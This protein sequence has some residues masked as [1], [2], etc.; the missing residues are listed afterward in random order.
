M[1]ADTTSRHQEWLESLEPRVRAEVEAEMAYYKPGGFWSFEELEPEDDGH[2]LEKARTTV[3]F[4]SE[5]SD[6]DTVAAA[7]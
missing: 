4:S 6:S 3:D 2:P 7:D 5:D 1:S